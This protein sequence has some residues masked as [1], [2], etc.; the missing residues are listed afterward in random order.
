LPRRFAARRLDALQEQMKDF[1]ATVRS[2]ILRSESRLA[3][4]DTAGARQALEQAAELAPKAVGLQLRLA[5]IYE[6]DGDFDRAQPLYELVLD[7]QPQNVVA[8]NNLAYGL[9]VHRK[10]PE[11]AR[12]LAAKAL[13]LAPREPTIADTM[14]W[15][16]HLLG[17][18]AAAAKL[19]GAA[20]KGAPNNKD[21][22]LHAAFIYAAGDSL[23]AAR[24]ELKAALSL[25]PSLSQRDDVQQLERRLA[26]T[27]DASHP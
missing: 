3:R 24:V 4:D 21:I 22:R 12:P 5:T 1:P 15:I 14:A 16:E 19:I 7:V 11:K 25:D 9:A 10:T 27:P 20:A 2:L 17:N 8:L 18:N 6:R 26:V 13:G 23:E